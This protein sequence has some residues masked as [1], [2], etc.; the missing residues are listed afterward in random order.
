MW[1]PKII[2][3][4]REGS[5][6]E[7]IQMFAHESCRFDRGIDHDDRVLNRMRGRT[8]ISSPGG[9]GSD[10]LQDRR[11]VASCRSEGFGAERRVVGSLCRRGTERLRAA[12]VKV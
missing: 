11:A 8:E 9:A 10:C 6:L 1:L 3:R 12:V 2:L 5:S 4:R 7:G